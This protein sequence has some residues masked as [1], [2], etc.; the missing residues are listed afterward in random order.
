M[1]DKAKRLPPVN[2]SLKVHQLSDPQIWQ[3][4]TTQGATI[5]NGRVNTPAKQDTTQGGSLPPT[6]GASS[7]GKPPSPEKGGPSK[8]L[9]PPPGG[10]P[11]GGPLDD[12]SV[13]R[14]LS[15]HEVVRF[16]PRNAV[17]VPLSVPYNTNKVSQTYANLEAHLRVL[18]NTSIPSRDIAAPWQVQMTV[19]QAARNYQELFNYLFDDVTAPAISRVRLQI[20][21]GHD[22]R[23]EAD[24]RLS[25]WFPYRGRGP[26][27]SRNSCLF[28]S[29]L[30][31]ARLWNLGHSVDHP[32][33][34]QTPW[35]NSLSDLQQSSLSMPFEPGW[36][37]W[38]VK[39]SKS[40]RHKFWR[41][42]CGRVQPQQS[43]KT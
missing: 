8:G 16:I 31:V 23:L 39:K 18:M 24:P 11:S 14:Q 30:V 28:D 41:S 25:H 2:R 21:G 13:I 38:T 26:V 6:E 7:S 19:N 10:D 1:I 32:G 12:G 17:K 29:M 40:E 35:L 36:E 3:I 43:R 9:L 34:L 22:Y 15:I 27:W 37:L 20:K 33:T 4:L 5:D 42:V